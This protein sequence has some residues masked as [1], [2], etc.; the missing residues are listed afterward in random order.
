MNE[1]L[2]GLPQDVQDLIALRENVSDM[3]TKKNLI[4]E[5]LPEPPLH[6]PG[7]DDKNHRFDWYQVT[8]Q[9]G[10]SVGYFHAVKGVEL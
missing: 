4:V 8:E 6:V 5:L 9:S 7:C 10:V 1:E 2:A 3:R